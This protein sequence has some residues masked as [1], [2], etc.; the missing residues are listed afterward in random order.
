[1]LAP[2]VTFFCDMPLKSKILAHRSFLLFSFTTDYLDAPQA[3]LGFSSG[4]AAPQ[5]LPQ[6]ELGFSS[7]L[8]APQAL[9]QAEAG[10]SSGLAA[11][12]A[13]PPSKPAFASIILLH[14]NKFFNAI[15]NHP[16]CSFSLPLF[17][18]HP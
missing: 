3:E 7:G 12:Q 5:A 2:L 11:P 10:F 15:V 8:A 1:M 18:V 13:V 14:P 6:A 17:L 4:L 9:P 16:F